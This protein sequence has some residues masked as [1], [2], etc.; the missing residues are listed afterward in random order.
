MKKKH[1][2][3]SERRACAVCR[4]T[5]AVT[6]FFSQKKLKNFG[7][8]EVQLRSEEQQAK[9]FRPKLTGVPAQ[10]YCN[11]QIRYCLTWSKS[12]PKA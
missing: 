7:P 1:I 5:Y 10:E 2:Y 8:S 3:W 12:Q 4:Q 11:V 9:L 6:I